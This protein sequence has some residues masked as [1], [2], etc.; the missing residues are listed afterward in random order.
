MKKKALIIEDESIN[1]QVLVK[2][3]SRY[4]DIDIVG[5]AKNREEAL[6]LLKTSMPDVI[7]LDILLPDGSGFDILP[8]VNRETHIIFTTGHGNYAVQAFEINA[9]D[10]LL[11]PFSHERLA[12]AIERIETSKQASQEQVEGNGEPEFRIKADQLLVKSKSEH[13]FVQLSDILSVASEGGNY[14]SVQYHDKKQAFIRKTLKEWADTLPPALFLHVHR[15]CIVNKTKI[16]RLVNDS[17]EHRLYIQGIDQ[18]YQVSR[19]HVAEIKK[20]MKTSA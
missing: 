8:Y 10:Y 6:V 16:V 1:T 9:V 15:G 5:Q 3:L 17:G 13:R 14:T 12:M 7:F 2:M 18:P 4:P 11:K 19:R 20:L